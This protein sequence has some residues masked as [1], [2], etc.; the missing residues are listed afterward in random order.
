MSND[1]LRILKANDDRL[2]QTE[3]K[4]V[5][6]GIPGFTSFYDIGTWVPTLVGSTIAGTFTYNAVTAGG[7]TR[8]GDR[9]LFDGRITITA[10][11][12]APTGNLTIRGLPIVSASPV[13]NSPGGAQF[14]YWSTV[15]LGG[16]ANVYLGGVIQN[17]QTI[18]ALTIAQ[19]AGGAVGL[20]TGAIAA[21]GANTE[22]VFQ[23][24]YQV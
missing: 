18:I 22:L 1:M 23:G 24:H 11:S 5:P 3:T 10:V 12:V 2:R 15:G 17:A 13:N 21:V 16:G 6:G 7:W 20:L 19:N 14:S 9:V 4:E 8:I